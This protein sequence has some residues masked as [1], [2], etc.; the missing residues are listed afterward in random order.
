MAGRRLVTDKIIIK[1]KRSQKGKWKWRKKNVTGR[2]YEYD[3]IDNNR[4]NYK[5][6]KFQVRVPDKFKK[7]TYIIVQPIQHPQ[8]KV[9]GEIERRSI[10][11][12]RA[13][14]GKYLA[15]AYA[16]VMLGDTDDNKNRRGVRIEQRRSL[17]PY[18]REFRLRAKQTVTTT[19]G[20]DGKALV[21]VVDP[22]AH[23]TMI[24]LFLATRAWVLFGGFNLKS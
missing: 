3:V 5:H 14:R 16:K 7:G 15:K 21:A 1:P 13:T 9:L 6:W 10:S 8:L 12:G 19:K 4:E 23:D 20:T 17:P 18:I 24:K 22:E 11:L 2:L